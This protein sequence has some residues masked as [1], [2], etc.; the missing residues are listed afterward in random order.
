M[1]LPR[2]KP[3][4]NYYYDRKGPWPQPQPSHPFGFAPGVVH[5]PKDEVKKWNWTIGIHYK[6][7]FLTYW[8]VSMKYAFQNRG[9]KP[10]SDAE[11][12]ELLTHSSFSKFI[13]N[14]LNEREKYPENEKLKIFKEFLDAEP[15]EKFFVSDFT[16]LEHCLSFPGIFTAP[17]ITLF[18]GDLVDGKRKVVA[19]YFPDTPLMLEPKDGNAWELAKYFVLQG[20]AIRISSSAHANLHFPYD[21]INAVSKTCLPKDSVLLRLLKPH[22]DLTLELNYSVLNSPTSPI[23]NNQKL[24]FAAFPAPEGGLAGMFL[25]GYNGIEGNPSYPKYKFQIVPDTYHSDYGTFLMAYYDTI[26]DFVHK[27]VEQIP[28][29]EYTDIMIW[30]DY[31]KTWVPEFPSGKEFFYL[32]HN[33]DAKFKKHAESGEKSLLSKVIANIIWDLSVGHAADHYDFSLID[34]NVAPLRL[35]VPPPDSKDIPPFDRKGIIHWG[36]IFRHHFERKMFFAPRNVTLLKDTVYNFNKPTE[37]TLRELNIYFLKDLQKTE[38]ELTVYN[39]IPLDQISRS[40][41]Y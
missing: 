28:P 34:I 3:S 16:L 11:F 35:R 36:D 10:V 6:I 26:F 33:G 12:E 25:Y 38:K 22:L 40:I 21:S 29:D 23:V 39:Y 30:A 27:V 18:K 5:V 41:Q 8:P 37:Q 20:A 4:S 19:I 9:L 24:P 2:V 1:S 14:E 17:T 31:V 15:N 13:S 7:T 32:D